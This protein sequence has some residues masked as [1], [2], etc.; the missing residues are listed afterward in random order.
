[1][2]QA[3]TEQWKRAQV[4]LSKD[5]FRLFRNQRYVGPIVNKGVITKGWANCGL[6]D[7]AGDLIGYEIKTV[8]P[9]MVGNKIAVF[10][11]IETK[12]KGGKIEDSQW[13]FHDRVVLDGGKSL[14]YK[15]YKIVEI[16][17]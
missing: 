10:S 13:D 9:D 15:D 7:G 14:F 2:K 5:G 17:R 4:D 6:C 8:T 1:M 16:K 12:I 3:E 11:S